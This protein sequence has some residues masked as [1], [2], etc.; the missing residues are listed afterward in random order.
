MND[1]TTNSTEINDDNL[2]KY[3]LSKL[4]HLFKLIRNEDSNV[5][6]HYIIEHLNK[7]LG[8]KKYFYLFL[9]KP[10]ESITNFDSDRI[11][12]ATDN[13]K[14]QDILLIMHSLG[15]L[16]EPA[17]FISKICKEQ[18]K[19]KF[20][21]VIPSRAKSAATLIALGADEIHMGLLSELGP[22]DPQINKNPALSL[23]SALECICNLTEKFPNT[24]SMFAEYLAKT[25]PLQQ[26][27]YF[28]RISDSAQHY[29]VRLLESKKEILKNSP[30]A[31]AQRLVYEYKDHSFVIDKDE[32]TE[33]FGE[34]VIKLNTDE[35][36]AGSEVYHFLEKVSLILKYEKKLD[37]NIVGSVDQI[38]F[39]N[40]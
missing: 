1:S 23:S 13:K 32:A 2:P 3:D 18:S 24:S 28:E 31:I 20:I 21:V 10:E 19:K 29:A 4:E 6:K 9:Y 17:Y 33:I 16:I 14:T 15:G 36:K 12:W 7:F 35:Y 34:K 40:C 11:Y 38:N 26:L 27:G 25:L 5:I 8:N 37:I 30:H 39:T 22:I